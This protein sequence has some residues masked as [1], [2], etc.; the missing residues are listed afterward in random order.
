MVAAVVTP[1][2]PALRTGDA[3]PMT[4]LVDQRGR[5]YLI[6]GLRPGATVVTFFFTTCRDA[7][8]CPLTSAKFARMQRL[9]GA[10]PAHITEITMDPAHDTVAALGRYGAAFGDKPTRLTLATGSAAAITTLERRLGFAVLRRAD[11][12]LTHGEAL[13]VLDPQGRLA[14][15]I[16]G[17]SWTP[18]Q[19]VA[20]LA[21]VEG[22]PADPIPRLTLA[23]TQGIRAACGGLATSG[24][25]SLAGVLGIFVAVLAGM[26]VV[27]RGVL[28]RP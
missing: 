8:E 4:A 20:V 19:A 25:M 10:D 17:N 14:D 13:I 18:A 11:G 24:G 7:N 1:F 15:R 5:A 6:G 12:N 3:L 26:S 16:E 23:L 9:L 22:R 28:K 2:V 27:M 21:A